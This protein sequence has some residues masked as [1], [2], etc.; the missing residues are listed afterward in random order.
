MPRF[1]VA[2]GVASR[3]WHDL[4]R[5]DGRNTGLAN[6]TRPVGCAPQG[7][8][9]PRERFQRPRID[10]ETAVSG[11]SL[12]PSGAAQ[13]ALAEDY[14]SMLAIGMLLDEDEPFGTLMHL[15]E[16]RANAARATA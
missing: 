15:I 11:I 4:V 8:V 6:R 14:A 12:V 5:L 13:E 9:L 3:H 1:R 7:D 2:S 16:E 10:Y